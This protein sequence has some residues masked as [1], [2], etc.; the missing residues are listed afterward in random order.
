MSVRLWSKTDGKVL[1]VFADC[2]FPVTCIAFSPNG[3]LLAAGGEETKIRIFDLAGGSQ[4]AELRDHSAYVS[5]MAW[6]SS[7]T[8]FA[9][10]CVDGSVRVWDVSKMTARYFVRKGIRFSSNCLVFLVMRHH[11]RPHYRL[12][13]G[14][15]GTCLD[16]NV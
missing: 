1:R 4:L 9:S 15:Y 7:S 8:K 11:S 5:S 14:F 3:K 6:N 16:V 13:P 10:C 12:V 2:R